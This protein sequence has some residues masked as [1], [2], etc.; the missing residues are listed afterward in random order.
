VR[1]IIMFLGII[2]LSSVAQ[3]Q[4]G[5]A[6]ARVI[7]RPMPSKA[8][9]G[10]DTIRA[11]AKLTLTRKG[12]VYLIEILKSSGDESFDKQWRKT[13]DEWRFIPAVTPEG[14]P[15]E[16]TVHVIYT[17]SG[18]TVQP[19]LPNGDADA[20]PRNVINESDRIEKLR[21]KDFAWEYDILVDALP[22]RFALLDP[23]LKTPQVMYAAATPLTEDQQKTLH[24]RYDQ[25][26]SDVARHCRDNPDEAFW[27]AVLKP[28]MD[29]ALAP[30]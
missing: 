9:S 15:I 22:R 26:L 14:E 24:D 30:Q 16:S 23:L 11:E 6:T 27:Q 8:P 2:A 13:L 7:S 28:A 25:V 10:V 21:C 20:T 1:Q 12:K 3:A 4:V 29:A 17:N 19:Y 18:L 5:P